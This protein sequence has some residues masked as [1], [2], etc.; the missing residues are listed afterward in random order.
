MVIGIASLIGAS[1][2]MTS[3]AS[4]KNNQTNRKGLIE[5]SILISG[6]NGESSDYSR[7]YSSDEPLT[8]EP[9]MY[10]EN[11]KNDSIEPKN[12]AVLEDDP[13]E[14]PQQRRARKQEESELFSQL[15]KIVKLPRKSKDQIL[16]R[17]KEQID[18]LTG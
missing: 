8:Q 4:L 12:D 2:E 13:D 18:K 6:M 11:A 9:P 7:R 3:V 5:F 14:T 17:A 15:S 1:L 16:A 10:E